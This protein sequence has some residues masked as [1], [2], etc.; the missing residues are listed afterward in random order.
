LHAILM[1]RG[2]A[3]RLENGKFLFP[4]ESLASRE[5]AWRRMSAD[6]KWIAVRQST[7]LNEI[8]LYRSL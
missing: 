6:P 4:F 2:H 5:Q 1:A 3:L 7:A 8:A